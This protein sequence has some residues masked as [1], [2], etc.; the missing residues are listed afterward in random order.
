MH[1]IKNHNPDTTMLIFELKITVFGATFNE[2]NPITNNKHAVKTT[3]TKDMNCLKNGFPFNNIRIQLHEISSHC[4]ALMPL[5]NT[6]KNGSNVIRSNFTPQGTGSCFSLTLFDPGRLPKVGDL[7]LS[8][9][10]SF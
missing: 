1:D 3:N 2:V 5:L 7:S 10:G 8:P 4:S 9:F 6:C